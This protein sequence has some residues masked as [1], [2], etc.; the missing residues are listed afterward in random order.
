MRQKLTKRVVD[1]APPGTFVWDAEVAGFGL[2]VTT[3]GKRVYVLQYRLG[4]RGSKTRRFTIG[5]HGGEMTVDEARDEAIKLRA[6]IR[7][8]GGVRVDP[9]ATKRAAEKAEAEARTFSQAADAWLT[10]VEKNRRASTAKE[11]RRIMERDVLPAWG[12][13]A[14]KNITRADV[15]ALVEGI[16]ERGAAIQANRTLSRLTTLFNWAVQKEMIAASPAA[17]I[18]LDVEE[19]ERD[20][21]LSDDEIR[22][23]WT[24]CDKLGWPFGPLF[25]LLLLTAQRRDEV[26]GLG[27]RHLDADMTIWKLPRELAKNDQGHDVPLA[28]QARHILQSVP[29]MSETLVFTTNGRTPV[30][31]FSKAKDRLDVLLVELSDAAP[32]QQA[33][34]LAAASGNIRI[35]FSGHTAFAGDGKRFVGRVIGLHQ[36]ERWGYARITEIISSMQVDAR[37]LAG[38]DPRKSMDAYVLGPDPWIIH[39]LRRTA[40]TGMARLNIQP[41]VVDRILNHVAGGIRGVARIYNRHAYLDERRVALDAW[42][43]RMETLL[44]GNPANVVPLHRPG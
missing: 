19:T 44:A 21:I 2:K 5:V 20:R 29:R 14:V 17:G 33:A 32:V 24:G 23:F 27:W 37:P 12:K 18:K 9:Q 26:G 8:S 4:G 35:A 30:S 1:A 6:Q 41:H 38:L 39:D 13:R 15:R 7:G 16:G 3:A 42:A 34:R 11:W 43:N 10:H 40:A 22:W 28:P 31:G 25:K 36:G